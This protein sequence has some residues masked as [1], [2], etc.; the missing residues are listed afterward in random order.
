MSAKNRRKKT[1]TRNNSPLDATIDD[2]LEFDRFR[3]EILPELRQMVLEGK[4]ASEILKKFEAHAAARLITNALTSLDAQKA[5]TASKEILDRTQG[6]AVER[7][8]I[9]HELADLEDKQLDAIL[10]TALEDIDEN[11]VKH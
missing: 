11:E 10:R 1:N 4:S 7:K 5:T 2:L 8:K 6:K 3:E 9:Q